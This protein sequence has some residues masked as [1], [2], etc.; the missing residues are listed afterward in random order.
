MSKRLIATLTAEH[1]VVLEMVDR[2]REN[3]EKIKNGQDL[4]SVQ[5][6]LWEFT[7]FMDHTLNNHIP[8]EEE[9][10]FPKLLK[11]NP[12]LKQEVNSMLD[13][14]KQIGEAHNQLKEALSHSQTKAILDSGNT[15]LD[16]IEEHVKREH[17]ALA[18]LNT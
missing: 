17:D 9:E 14:H 7:R 13:D 8:H 4:A 11:K 2:F 1:L 3:L 18:G 6:G 12:S 16:T 10:L 15:I 5:D